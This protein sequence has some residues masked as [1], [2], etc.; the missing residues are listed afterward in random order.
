MSF[1][2][3]I[4]RQLV[5]R[6]LWPV[7]LLLVAA[8][9]AIPV[10]LAKDPEV[11][12]TAAPPAAPAVAASELA[13][14]PIVTVA[15]GSTRQPGRTVL[16]KPRDIF[17]STAK[18][19]KT[20]K[21]DE[22]PDADNPAQTDKPDTDKGADAPASGGATPAPAAPPAPPAPPA[23][24]PKTYP[25]YAL[26]VRFSSGGQAVKGYLPVRAALPSTDNPLII[27]LGLLDD[28]KTAVFMLDS[29]IEAIGDGE[30]NPTPENC[31][32]VRMR[33]GDTMFFDVIGEDGTAVGQQ[34][35]IDL[36]DINKKQTTDAAKSARSA[37]LAKVAS[38][39]S[40]RGVATGL[41]RDSL[42]RLGV[43]GRTG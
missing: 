4:W 38:A 14:A 39:S 35:Q 32:T 11:T 3:D 13:E 30:C 43:V 18:K 36:L 34:F 31:E 28:H 29:T 42:R 8:I 24:K 26:K 25:R 20:P 10:L 27:Y 6:R 21:A 17:A 37:R 1:L 5:R 23:P 12:P 9:A 19:P 41:G 33:E 2:T 15:D 16:G 22:K 7:A 40:V